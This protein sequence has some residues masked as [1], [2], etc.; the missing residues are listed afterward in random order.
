MNAATLFLLH[1]L[2][3]FGRC[4]VVSSESGLLLSD[5]CPCLRWYSPQPVAPLPQLDDAR[6]CCVQL[7]E[8]LRFLAGIIGPKCAAAA[9]VQKHA[10][11]IAT[12][13]DYIPRTMLELPV[14]SL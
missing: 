8:Q 3:S 1:V 7:S 9:L 11:T 12:R 6:L 2:Q 14:Q 5:S 13:L 4:G 10:P